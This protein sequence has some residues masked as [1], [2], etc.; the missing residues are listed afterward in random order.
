MN[1]ETGNRIWAAK[2]LCFFTL[3]LA[4]FQALPLAAP[5]LQKHQGW[6]MSWLAMRRGARYVGAR[7]TFFQSHAS[8]CGAASL[9]LVLSEHGIYC[10]L[11]VLEKELKTTARGTSMYNL[12]LTATGYGVPARSWVLGKNDL[13]GAPLPAIARLKQNH[14][15]V[16]RRFAAPSVLEISDPA[17]GC[18]H[19]PLASF[20]RWWQGE[21]LIFDPLWVPH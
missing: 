16:I 2:R 17:I 18:L 6:R 14:F 5:I 9:K 15:V 10:S 11:S 3:A 20:G 8:D 19:W 12:R 13:R 21:T 4:G 1:C 7:G